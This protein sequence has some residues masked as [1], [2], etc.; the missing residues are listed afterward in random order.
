MIKLF[1]TD[2]DGC[3][4]DGGYFSPSI[5]ELSCNGM[6]VADFRPQLYLR[7]FNTCDFVGIKMLSDAGIHCVALTGSYEPGMPQF[8]RAGR[9]MEVCPGV[10]DKF[11]FVKSTFVDCTDRPNK[12]TWDEIAFIGDEINDCVLLAAVGLAAC[13]ADAAREV[14][15]VVEDKTETMIGEGFVMKRKGGEL[16]VREFTDMIRDMQGIKAS[17]CN[18]KEK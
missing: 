8:D 14:I 10:Q 7:K 2:I 18:W 5:P 3:L 13:P 6:K 1:I 16:C 17:W 15:T 11:N 9:D 4:T 12:C